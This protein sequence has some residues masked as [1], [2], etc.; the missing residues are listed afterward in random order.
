MHPNT[1]AYTNIHTH[2]R[3]FNCNGILLNKRKTHQ[4]RKKREQCMVVINRDGYAAHWRVLNTLWSLPPP[5]W[6]SQNYLLYT[7]IYHK[8][9]NSTWSLAFLHGF[10]SDT[11]C[12]LH[13]YM[14]ACM[15]ACMKVYMHACKSA[16]RQA[17]IYPLVAVLRTCRTWWHPSLTCLV[18]RDWDPPA[19][20]NM[21]FHGWN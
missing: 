13:A 8:S 15:H 6:C 11:P 17:C 18:V 4:R 20:S 5:F 10:L 16:G 1:H 7:F 2:K 19:V 3:L 14:P 21:N 12:H 9:W